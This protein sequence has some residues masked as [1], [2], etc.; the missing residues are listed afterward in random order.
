MCYLKIDDEKTRKLLQ[1]LSEEGAVNDTTASLLKKMRGA[2]VIKKVVHRGMTGRFRNPDIFDSR[3]IDSEAFNK[4]FVNGS[5]YYLPQEKVKLLKKCSDAVTYTIKKHSATGDNFVPIDALPEIKSAYL[6]E[7]EVYDSVLGELDAYYDDYISMFKEDLRGS[8]AW[9]SDLTQ[10][11]KDT[12]YNAF[13]RKIPTREQFMESQA[14]YM[15]T[16]LLPVFAEVDATELPAED[17]EDLNSS[18]E[19][20]YVRFAIA[21]IGES[22]KK[23]KA[24]CSAIASDYHAFEMDKTKAPIESRSLTN[25]KKHIPSLKTKNVFKNPV[26]SQIIESLEEGL[27][28]SDKKLAAVCEECMLRIDIYA[29]ETGLELE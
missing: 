12:A 19:D 14:F 23:C 3:G 20:K 5:S 10:E 13:I 22:L 8:L 21:A 28:L 16:E 11:E 17:L 24:L 2:G 27:A 1:G 25:L 26:I 4:I 18:T 29:K 15:E 7:K 9:I 6:K